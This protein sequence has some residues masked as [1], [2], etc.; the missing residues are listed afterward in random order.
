MADVVYPDRSEAGT[1]LLTYTSAP[2]PAD[3]EIT[4]HPIVTLNVASST[5]DPAF[6][7]YLEDVAPDGRVTY[8]TEGILRGIHSQV[9]FEAPAYTEFGPRHTMQ[10]GDAA[11]LIPRKVTEVSFK[12]FATSVLIRRGHAI[13]ISIAGVDASTFE[14]YPAEG[15]VSF[16]L[17]RNSATPSFVV[18]PVQAGK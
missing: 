16:T 8:I 10:R 5:A 2:L 12:M 13:R 18:L 15:E 14:R 9:S 6:H 11:G 4:G 1:K 3:L 7:V 17:Q